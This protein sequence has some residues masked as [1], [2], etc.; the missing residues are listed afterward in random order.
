M[1]VQWCGYCRRGFPESA[2]ELNP[3]KRCPTCQGPLRALEQGSSH[4]ALGRRIPIPPIAREAAADPARRLGR[5]ALV[6]E[7]GRGAVGT[8]EQAWDTRLGRWV[9]IKLLKAGS[10]DQESL[11]R[12]RQEASVVASLDHPSIAPVY[13]VIESDRGLAIIMK[14]IDGKTLHEIYLQERRGPAPIEDAVRIIRDASLGLGYAHGRGFVHRD[15]KPGNI[16][17][18]RDSRVFV[19]DFGF[20]KIL[21]Q[22]GGP[23]GLGQIMGTPAYMS[24]EQAM[25]LAR[26]VDSRSDVF[27][28]GV[29]LWTLL[30]GCRPFKGKTDLE[31]ATSIVRNPTPSAKNQ[32]GDI[33][34][35]LEF[36]LMKA[37]EK[38]R[39][40]RFPTA[41]EFAAALNDCLVSIE[42][43]K[44]NLAVSDAA[45]SRRTVLMVEDDVAVANMVRK[46]LKGDGIEIVHFSDGAEALECIQTAVPDLVLLDVNLPGKSG[47]EIL[48]KLR[49]LPSYSHV[50]I[51]MVTG[52]RG[53]E[54]AVKGYQMGANDYVEKPFSLG[55]L[56]ARVRKQLQRQPAEA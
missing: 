11:D 44:E 31:V 53:E 34:D 9:A 4:A 22:S 27:S 25:G 3:L 23:T 15:L 28:L 14:F 19:V 1:S 37:M 26:D 49:S 51:M 42:D 41:V 18:D 17:V 30:I 54:N 10:T 24:P 45:P 48:A 47:W 12:F 36:A 20:A 8:V 46:L 43:S 52:E 6:R 29:T 40:A 2:V 35:E 16:M 56:R 32:R 55:V 13:D 21:A 50:P 33:P 5:F 38:D 7:L 39:E